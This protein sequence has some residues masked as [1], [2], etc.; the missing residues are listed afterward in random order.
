MAAAA[1]QLVRGLEE[2]GGLGVGTQ[3]DYCVEAQPPLADDSVDC[4]RGEYLE[5]YLRAHG[6]AAPA[7]DAAPVQDMVQCPH[8]PRSFY[9]DR[10]AKHVKLCAKEAARKAALEEARKEAEEEAGAAPEYVPQGCEQGQL[11]RYHKWKANSTNLRSMLEYNRN[12]QK[13]KKE[14]ADP[15]ALPPPPAAEVDLRVPCPHCKRKFNKE[16]AERHIPK[17]HAANPRMKVR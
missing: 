3:G 6:A 11:A 10:L 1:A 8:C 12:L 17:C 14:G 4:P 15:R 2:E 9:P 13:A 7:L 16:V 5:K